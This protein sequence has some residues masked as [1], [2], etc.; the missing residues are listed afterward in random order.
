[1]IEIKTV[2]Y[3]YSQFKLTYA[4]YLTKYHTLYNITKH[5]ITRFFRNIYFFNLNVHTLFLHLLLLH[6]YREL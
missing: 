5:M 6:R 4:V 3:L 2:S 1:M